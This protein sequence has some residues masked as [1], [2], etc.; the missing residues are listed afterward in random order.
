MI[1][2][3]IKTATLQ[4]MN[5]YVQV[6]EVITLPINNET[7]FR[8]FYQKITNYEHLASRRSKSFQP[9]CFS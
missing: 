1:C 9:K 6:Q 5:N 8:I 7:N 3:V 4:N 2:L